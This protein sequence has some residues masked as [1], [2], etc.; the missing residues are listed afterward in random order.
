MMIKHLYF[1]IVIPYEQIPIRFFSKDISFISIYKN[2][3]TILC[4]IIL[5]T[6]GY[7][8][9]RGENIYTHSKLFVYFHVS[10]SLPLET[11]T[12][13]EK[14]SF[15]AIRMASSEGECLRMGK[16][17]RE[18]QGMSENARISFRLL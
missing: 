2:I 16:N 9:P 18:W 1:F 13:G 6:G 7:Y 11:C 4:N 15:G 17:S 10:L 5:R 3:Q 12:Q 8:Y 14:S